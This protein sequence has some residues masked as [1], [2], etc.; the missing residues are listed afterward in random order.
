MLYLIVSRY[1]VRYEQYLLRSV[2]EL[3]YWFDDSISYFCMPLYTRLSKDNVDELQDKIIEKLRTELKML[4]PGYAVGSYLTLVGDFCFDNFIILALEPKQLT[5]SLKLR[6]PLIFKRYQ[7]RIDAL[8]DDN[9]VFDSK[10]LE[11]VDILLLDK[12]YYI[13]YIWISYYKQSGYFTLLPVELI[14]HLISF[15]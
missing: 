5:T 2:E 1:E 12:W 13:K 6:L 8:Y 14:N 3:Q 9:Y 15:F 10:V 7:D 11:K 4:K